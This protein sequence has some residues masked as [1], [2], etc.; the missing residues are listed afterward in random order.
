MQKISSKSVEHK[1]KEEVTREDL[2][3][4]KEI[5]DK[6]HINF[7][8]DCGVLLGAVREQRF[9]P[10]DGDAEFGVWN[11][12]TAKIISAC[13]EL[14]ERGFKIGLYRYGICLKKPTSFIPIST[15]FYHL[16]NDKAIGRWGG[17]NA[18]GLLRRFLHN[19]FWMLLTPHYIGI[20]PK[21]IFGVKNFIRISLA[22]IGY[23]APNFIKKWLAGIELRQGPRYTW[24]IPSHY[25]T[26]LS[27]IKFYGMEFRV[28]SKTEEYL[29]YRYGK[30][31]RVPKRNWDTGK[32]DGGI[33]ENALL[34]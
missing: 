27:T 2:K 32:D 25:F 4:V 8:L 31:W 30:N 6:H 10:W 34:K 15:L 29:A 19:L 20:N 21:R 3:E 22:N 14:Q 28:P 7:W 9:I 17:Y 1:T 24:V 23:L 12:D 33:F 18:S 16:T 13:Q 5:F 26:S 11:K